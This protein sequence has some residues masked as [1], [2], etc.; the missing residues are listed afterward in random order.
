MRY[1]KHA[2]AAMLDGHAELLDEDGIQDMRHWSNQAAEQND[3][4]FK[5]TKR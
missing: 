4:H 5:L 1:D 2:V 3:P